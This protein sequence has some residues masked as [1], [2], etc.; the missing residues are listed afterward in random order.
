M[1]FQS[2]PGGIV[3]EFVHLFKAVLEILYWWGYLLGAG[4]FDCLHFIFRF[5]L[6]RVFGDTH[7][8][9][10]VEDATF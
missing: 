1:N 9:I 7:M 6:F 3:V 10:F 5:F 4:W 8:G 2:D